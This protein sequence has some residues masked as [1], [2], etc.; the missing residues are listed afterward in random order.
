[1]IISALLFAAQATPV[2]VET[3]AEEAD[4]IVIASKL[5]DWRGKF[6]VKGEKVSCKTVTSTRDKEIDAVGCAAL[7]QCLTPLKP[8][9][10]ES[11]DK[12]LGKNRQ[13]ELKEAISQDLRDCVRDTRGDLIAE[14]SA[15]RKAKQ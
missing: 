9:L 13:R 2:A 10:Q 6:S 5:K 14:L 8:R 3:A 7:T 12:A 11:D 4:I 15:T 1:M